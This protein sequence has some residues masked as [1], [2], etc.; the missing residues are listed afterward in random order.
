MKKNYKLKIINYILQTKG[1]GMQRFGRIQDSPLPSPDPSPLYQIPADRRGE[2]RVRPVKEQNYILRQPPRLKLPKRTP[3][4]LMLLFVFSLG[5]WGETKTGFF[6]SLGHSHYNYKTFTRTEVS[7]LVGEPSDLFFGVSLFLKNQFE[8]NLIYNRS[9][10][11]F[12]SNPQT[13]SY[14]KDGFG[15][16]IGK[17]IHIHLFKKS[18]FDVSIEFVG[19]GYGMLYPFKKINSGMN[20]SFFDKSDIPGAD[21]LYYQAGFYW[22]VRL[23]YLIAKKASID[24]GF[25]SLVP[26]R[27]N[28]FIETRG[29]EILLTKSFFLIGISF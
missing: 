6:L 9:T 12:G 2:P 1:T 14:D 8:V 13:I 24:I 21:D 29:E 23:Q 28:E 27:S 11:D 18:N 4:V 7:N 16:E 25:K 15:L 22:S 5:A 17:V 3:L 20:F 26:V 19:G 10:E